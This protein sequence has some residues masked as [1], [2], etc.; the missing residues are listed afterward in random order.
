MQA[1]QRPGSCTTINYSK[2]AH[3]SNVL[4]RSRT[5]VVT[6]GKAPCSIHACKTCRQL[7][8]ST[9]HG[10]AVS[11]QC[12]LMGTALPPVRHHLPTMT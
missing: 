1:A 12:S 2:T 5:H 3:H 6:F 7:I 9:Y 4:L 10:Y 11:A 8:G